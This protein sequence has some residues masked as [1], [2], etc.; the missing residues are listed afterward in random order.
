MAQNGLQCV[1]TVPKIETLF[2]VVAN[3]VEGG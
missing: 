2:T 3:G 1:R